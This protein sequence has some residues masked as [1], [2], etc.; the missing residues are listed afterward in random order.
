[1]GGQEIAVWLYFGQ[2][3]IVNSGRWQ[4]AFCLRI[5]AFCR[6]S[7]MKPPTKNFTLTPQKN[8]LWKVNLHDL[9][10]FPFLPV[11]KIGFVHLRGAGQPTCLDLL[12]GSWNQSLL[13]SIFY[14]S[15]CSW[16]HSTRVCLLRRYWTLSFWTHPYSC[17]WKGQNSF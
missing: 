5:I 13:G 2:R 17:C 15:K 4:S 10:G 12:R 8:L 14:I 1:M 9:Q 3:L 7:W 16:K 11:C 6:P